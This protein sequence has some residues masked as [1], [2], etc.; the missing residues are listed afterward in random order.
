MFTKTL[1][2]KIRKLKL[3]TE[4]III[5]YQK[6]NIDTHTHT[7]MRRVLE[8]VGVERSIIIYIT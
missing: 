8:Y 6:G 7:D 1:S 3:P 2:K 4:E 5:K